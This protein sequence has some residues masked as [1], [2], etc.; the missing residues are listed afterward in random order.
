[1]LKRNNFYDRL[2]LCQNLTGALS[3]SFTLEVFDSKLKIL[4]PL[5]KSMCSDLV[6][7]IKPGFLHLRLPQIDDEFSSPTGNA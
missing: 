1:M 3:S 7:Y 2:S 4:S 5:V 6:K